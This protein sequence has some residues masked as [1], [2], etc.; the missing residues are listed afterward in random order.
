MMNFLTRL[1]NRAADPDSDE[2]SGL[3]A[4][5]GL[6]ALLV[7]A[8]L[9][10]MFL[11]SSFGDHG[12]QARSL[13]AEARDDLA[14]GRYAEAR[15]VAMRLVQTGELAQSACVLEA[16]ALQGLGRFRE[17]AHLLTGVAPDD[18]PGYAPAHVARAVGLFAQ[19]QPEPADKQ[20]DL[21]LLADPS[22]Q[23]ALELAARIADGKK[24]WKTTLARIDGIHLENRPDLMLL[25]AR[26]LQFS[27][28]E[29]GALQWAAKA[30]TALRALHGLD[31]DSTERVQYSIAMSL[32][33]QHKFDTAVD[34]LVKNTPA[35]QARQ[36]IG[37]VYFAWSQ[38]LKSVPGLDQSRVLELLQKGLEFCPDNQDLLTA[39]LNECDSST[40]DDESRRQMMA[41]VL[42]GGGV[43]TSFLHYYLG[44]QDWKHGNAEAARSH[45]EMACKINPGFQA[46]T[47]NLAMAIAALSDD[48]KDLNRALAMMEP[49]VKQ[50]PGNPYFLDTRGHVLARLGRLDAAVR[51]LETAL[52]GIRDK[53]D[54]HAKLAEVYEKLAMHDLA[55]QHRQASIAVAAAK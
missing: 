3:D 20:V 26:A 15:I 49:L 48:P 32:T 36:V 38:Y 52:P 10:V 41:R 30:E 37:G 44:A 46:V 2:R 17:A 54:T 13:E 31:R 53:G 9:G 23:D 43:P 6:G 28:I 27:G 22:N 29:A 51:D 42:G 5:L 34:G 25:K 16:K 8:L 1:R 21:A 12:E 4:W 7:L 19:Q 39:F 14:H 35:P 24:D 47:N 50:E 55:T 45:F 33:L 18:H 40:P 11:V